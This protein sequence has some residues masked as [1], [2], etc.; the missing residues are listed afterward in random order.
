MAT[1]RAGAAGDSAGSND[2]TPMESLLG[3]TLIKQKVLVTTK[4]AMK[5]KDLVLL[6]FSASWCPPCKAFSPILKEF[7]SLL[8]NTEK[9]EVVYVSSDRT[10]EEFEGYY[11]QMPWL[12]IESVDLK[13][14]LASMLQIRGIPALIVLDS[15]TGKFVSNDARNDVQAAAG[16]TA[17]Y[18]EVVAKW[19]SKEPVPIEQGLPSSGAF[20]LR[21]VIMAILKNPMY[22]FGTIYMVKYAYRYFFAAMKTQDVDVPTIEHEQIPDDEF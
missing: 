3:K 7:Y 13:K 21:G 10:V 2:T 8:H 6:Y 4:N 16:N 19:K 17:K 11:G 5:D 18:K 14:R 20:S 1:Q 9:I 22:I 12:A 15:K